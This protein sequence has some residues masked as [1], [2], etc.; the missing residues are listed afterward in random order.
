MSTSSTAHRFWK[1]GTEKPGLAID[2]E[3]SVQGEIAGPAIA[4]NPFQ[5]LS[6]EKQRQR[7]PIFQYRNHILYLVE[8]YQT[9]II[10][11]ETGCGKSTQIPQFLLEA[12]WGA[13]GHVIGVTQPRR[14]AAITVASRIA[15]ER[16][17]ILGNEVGYTIRFDDCSDPS[18]TRILFM[19]D[20]MMIREIMKDPLL[21]KYSVILL[22]EA[23]ERALN[24]DIILGLLRKIQKKRPDL[25]LLVASATLDA[26]EMRDFF[27]TNETGDPEKDTSTILTVEGREYP[28]DVHYTLDPVPDYLKATVDT[29]MKIHF[30]ERPGD[31]LAFLTGMEEVDNVVHRLIEEAKKLKK[32]DLKMTVLPMYGSLPASE[33]MKV[34]QKPPH[35]SRKIVVATNI[36]EASITI[37]G[38][39]YVVDCGFVKLKA[40]DPS[41]G[42]ESL[43]VI[44]VSKA[45]ANQRAGRAGRVRA[46]KAFRLYTEDDFDKL[47]EAT[48]PEMQRSDLAPVVLQL[49]AL[50][51][52]NILRFN[53]LSPPPAQ[54]MVRGLELLYALGALDS[55]GNLT[56]PL[57]LQMVE[58]PLSPCFAKMLLVSGDYECSEE[59]LT[60]AAMTQIQN[61]FVTP[62]GKRNTADKEKRKFA[63]LEGDHVTL[64]NVYKAFIKF[65]KNSKWCS[66][67]FLNY[68]GLK[69][70]IEIR[71]QLKRL[72]LKFKV[73]LVSC[74]DDVLKLRRCITA[75]FFANAVRLHYTGVYR[76]VRDGH[77][78]YIHPSSVLSNE[79]QPQWLIFNEVVHTS[80]EYMRDVTTIEPDWLC[81]LAPHFYQFGTEREISA[82]R[83]R[84]E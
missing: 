63:V 25:R 53:F 82:K 21:S 36:A 27:N 72:L 19:T 54:N 18:A 83:S 5:T 66:E 42:V 39:V 76:T 70:A 17:S 7:L 8:R 74:Q 29:V 41:S 51:I 43:V 52:A 65:G 26:E 67:H 37:N 73:P 34:F 57:G 58:F 44:P 13:E 1:P 12:G 16:G 81:E 64:L 75:A 9:V 48:V 22:D 6:I 20:G 23:H 32:E 77:E 2:E 68:K 50:G 15:E 69:R 10:I 28:V 56:S 79:E 35:N 84:L 40:Y 4:Y 59:V 80:K 71:E 31:V 38:I 46:G 3:R 60:V 33:Q 24:T 47:S 55:V 30:N 49:K 62:S 45:S 14:I 61:V 78:L 11:G